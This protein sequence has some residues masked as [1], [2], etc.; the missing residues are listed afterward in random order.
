MM[1]QEDCMRYFKHAGQ[2][3][4]LASLLLSGCGQNPVADW[5]TLGKTTY[6]NS[7]SG[8]HGDEG[9]GIPN[10]FPP[11]AEHLPTIANRE[12]GNDYLINV[13]LYGLQGEIRVL[14]ET[15]NGNMPAYRQLEDRTLAAVTN[16]ML[17]AWGNEELLPAG[18]PVLQAAD[19][20]AL[21][22]KNLSPEDVLRQRQ[23]LGLD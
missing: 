22:G 15:Y 16:Y 14:G 1:Q 3:L 18:Y 23:A 21:R 10:T 12:S 13:M 19:I 8:C 17:R 11:L 4:I 2:L 20:A 6:D 9:E 7:C 5:Q